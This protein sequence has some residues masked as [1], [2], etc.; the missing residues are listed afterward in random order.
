MLQFLY[1]SLAIFIVL[2]GWIGVQQLYQR[3]ALRNPHLGP[4]RTEAEGCSSCKCGQG[5]CSR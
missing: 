1:A 4:F 2:V 3:F 5:Q